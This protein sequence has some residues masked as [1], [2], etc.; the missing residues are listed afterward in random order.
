MFY[1]TVETAKNRDF[2]GM[3]TPRTYDFATLEAAKQCYDELTRP[4]ELYTLF[5]DTHAAPTIGQ[6]DRVVQVLLLSE[7]TPG[8]IVEETF[9]TYEDAR[10]FAIS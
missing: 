6:R 9:Y 10:D 8:A 1:V 4:G 2:L 5:C 3:S 7:D